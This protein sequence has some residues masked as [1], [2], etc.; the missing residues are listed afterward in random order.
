VER[1]GTGPNGTPDQIKTETGGW[2]AQS[3]PGRF[4]PVRQVRPIRRSGRLPGERTDC[5]TVY[6]KIVF[7]F[8]ILPPDRILPSPFRN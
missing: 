3:G 8:V 1:H 6:D 2:S 4:Q 7:P 5:R